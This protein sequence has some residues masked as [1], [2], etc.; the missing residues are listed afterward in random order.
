[1]HLKHQTKTIQQIK[2]FTIA[3][4]AESNI[5]YAFRRKKIWQNYINFAIEIESFSMTNIC[6][7]ELIAQ[8]S[9]DHVEKIN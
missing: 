3:V 2:D 1:M 5:Y 9:S 7:M 6:K 4:P 8:N